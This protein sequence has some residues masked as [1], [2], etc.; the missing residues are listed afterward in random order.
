[1]T[2][3]VYRRRGPSRS[4]RSSVTGIRWL[5]PRRAR[6]SC[7]ARVGTAGKL[8][9]D[10]TA[11]EAPLAKDKFRVTVTIPGASLVM[12]SRSGTKHG[13]LWESDKEMKYGPGIYIDETMP[14]CS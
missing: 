13:I 4:T 11:Q 10:G 8:S 2:S 3:T 9:D 1:M 6:G 12:R 7:R 5:W 14:N